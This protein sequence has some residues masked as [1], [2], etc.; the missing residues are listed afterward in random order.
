MV[1]QLTK[2]AKMWR[3]YEFLPPRNDQGPENG[4]P[5]SVR[6]MDCSG[7]V[8]GGTS[9][10]TG[11]VASPSTSHHRILAEVRAESSLL[12]PSLKT[13]KIVLK[14]KHGA[15]HLRNFSGYWVLTVHLL[16]TWSLRYFAPCWSRAPIKDQH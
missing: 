11:G 2:A 3:D 12:E 7:S 4:D 1:T 8:R 15:T 14:G 13:C 16:L 9:G 5:L 6:G 10:P